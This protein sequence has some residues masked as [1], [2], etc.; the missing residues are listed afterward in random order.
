MAKIE[1]ISNLFALRRT[2]LSQIHIIWNLVGFLFTQSAAKLLS[3]TNHQN[4]LNKRIANEVVKS[5]SKNE[6]IKNNSKSTL[7]RRTQVAWEAR[8]LWPL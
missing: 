2:G 4:D 7:H 1:A 5:N 6:V 8:T 3:K